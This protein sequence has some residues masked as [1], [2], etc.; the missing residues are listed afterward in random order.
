[1][2][3][4]CLSID[5]AVFINIYPIKLIIY[6]QKIITFYMKIKET[7]LSYALR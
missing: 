1:M 4:L 2:V 7:Q 5:N 6:H 3:R